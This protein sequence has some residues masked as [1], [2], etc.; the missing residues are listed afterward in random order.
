MNHM[1]PQ[2]DARYPQGMATESVKGS[3]SEFGYQGPRPMRP[4]EAPDHLSVQ[5]AINLISND[6][7]QL[8]EVLG[9][10]RARLSPILAEGHSSE[11]RGGPGMPVLSKT[12][13]ELSD[14][15]SNVQNAR[16]LVEIT[17]LQLDL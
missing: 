5:G 9:E 8:L 2:V 7:R 1:Q 6:M 3:P 13:A 17:L 12:A 10:L 4:H 11:R 16:E 15:H 14:I